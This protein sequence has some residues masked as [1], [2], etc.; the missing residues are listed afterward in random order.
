MGPTSR[1]DA[2][3]SYRG[4]NYDI[5]TQEGFDDDGMLEASFTRHTS[6]CYI[7]SDTI[8]MVPAVLTRLILQGASLLN[9][10]SDINAHVHHT[11]NSA[12]RGMGYGESSEVTPDLEE[13]RQFFLNVPA[14]AIR[15]TYDAATWH[16]RTFSSPNHI[17]QLHRSA[18][19]T[20]NVHRRNEAVATDTVFS[21]AVAFGGWTCA[22]F[23]VGK[24][25]RY[26][27]L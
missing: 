3:P 26:I 19:P 20:C 9:Q 12:S 27:S 24:Q 6:S 2:S 18:Y 25:T 13:R 14:E 8:L 5:T 4:R 23:F 17:K 7:S 15:L 10:S 11:V 1:Y 21:D 22:Q 16:Y